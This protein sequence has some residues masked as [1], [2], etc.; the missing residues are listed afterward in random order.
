MEMSVAGASKRD[1]RRRAEESRIRQ[2]TSSPSTST[3]LLTTN[4]QATLPNMRLP[5]LAAAT[6]VRTTHLSAAG[7]A[8][9]LSAATSLASSS[10][11]RSSR[12]ILK[13]SRTPLARRTPRRFSSTLES[14]SIASDAVPTSS[15]I[16]YTTLPNRVRVAT[17][18]TPGHFSAAGVY[19]DAGSRFERTGVPGE[20]GVSHLLDRMAFKVSL[21]QWAR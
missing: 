11:Q 12:G 20:S 14:S 5:A 10:A 1:A 7:A 16:S 13:P 3:Q 9:A 21:T 17:E 8:R 18:A 6:A 4:N 19:V 15:L 2:T